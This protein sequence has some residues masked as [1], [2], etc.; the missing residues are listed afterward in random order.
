MLAVFLVGVL[1][2]ATAADGKIDPAALKK[3]KAATVHIKVTLA[4][5]DTNEGSGFVT[6]AKGLV[7]TNAHVVG[8]LDNDSKKPTKVEVTFNSGETNSKTVVARVGFVDGDSDLALLQLGP[9][10]VK[11]VPELLQGAYSAKLME[12]QDVFIVGFPLGKQA[13]PN[14]TVTA[15]TVTSLRK[16]GNNIKHVQVNGGMHPGNSG[17]P[18]VDKDGKLVGIAV[19]AFAG[20]QLHLAIPTEVLNGVLNGRVTNSVYEVSYRDGDKIKVP[21]HFTKADPLGKMKTIAIE[22]WMGKPGPTRSSPPG[23]K[24]EPL[25]DDTPVTVLDLKPDEKGVYSGELVLDAN[26][27]PKLAYWMRYQVGRGGEN[28]A[29]YPAGTLTARVGTPVDRKAATMK[30]EPPLDKADTLSLTSDASFRIRESDGDDH[31]LAMT[32]KGTLQEKVTD[33]MKDGKWRKRLTYGGLE[34][35]AT[36]D[37]KPLE[38]ADKLLKALKD[39]TLLAS[40]IDVE[41][42]GTIVRNLLDDSKVPAASKRPLGLVSEQVQQSLDSLALPL[43]PKEVE[44]LATWKGKQSYTLGALGLAVPAKA[45]IT[46]KY[47]GTYTRDNQTVA[48]VSFEGPLEREVT[49]KPKK[50]VKEPTMHG[51]V[52]GKIEIFADTGLIYYA[53]ERVKAELDL[54]FD[55]KPAKAI[56][57]LNVSLRRVPPAPPKKP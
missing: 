12:T 49:K 2:A 47:E 9:D 13:G 28:I 37:K 51:K 22:S 16:E 42:D 10:G 18:L 24:P 6:A 29:W 36:V 55:D 40:E 57:I 44:A 3:V 34:T 5:G 21:F 52:E 11:E 48:V 14:V 46:Y 15:T 56:G 20:T 38:G 23:M 25:P 35:T 32:L 50:G 19:A 27:D 53:T 8:M 31:T 1:S 41:K 7:V 54:E 26:K 33:H 39:V 4:D 45:E 30:Y 17:G 43:P